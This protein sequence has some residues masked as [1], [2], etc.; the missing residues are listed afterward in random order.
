MLASQRL[1]LIERLSIKA[2]GYRNPDDIIF[3]RLANLCARD[4]VQIENSAI[5]LAESR[6]VLARAN[7]LLRHE[8]NG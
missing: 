1:E 5:L 2:R 3:T 4:S 7:E 8:P 6:R